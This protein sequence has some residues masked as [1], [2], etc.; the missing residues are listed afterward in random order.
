MIGPDLPSSPMLMCTVP[1][2]LG[3]R[4]I[5]ASHGLEKRVLFTFG[6]NDSLKLVMTRSPSLVTFALVSGL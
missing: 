1:S 6:R 3:G 5:S 2:N 4:P